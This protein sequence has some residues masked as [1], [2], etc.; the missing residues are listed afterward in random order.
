MD[1]QSPV[2][3]FVATPRK[4]LFA[5][6]L[7]GLLLGILLVLFGG[8]GLHAV[9]SSSSSHQSITT[10]DTPLYWVAPMDANYRRDEPGKS[11]MGMDL[12]PVYERGENSSAGAVTIAPEVI[13]S[14]GVKTFTVTR[15]IPDS[16]FSAFGELAYPEHTQVSIHSR[17]T[18]W[19][20]ELL[21]RTNGAYVHQGQPLYSLYAPELVFAQEEYLVALEQQS[22]PLID[23][24]KRRLQ[25]LAAPEP[26]IKSLTE[27]RTVEQNVV[28]YA[29]QDGFVINLAVKEGMYIKPDLTFMTLVDTSQMWLI[30][31][32]Y[33]QD[34]N[35]V[36]IGQEVQL[37]SEI[38]L[39]QTVTGTIDYIY[40]A[41]S[42]V[43]RTTQVRVV[44]P[45]PK[46]VLR[47]GQ[48]V[49]AEIIPVN[50]VEPRLLVP[51]DAII[52][53]GQ[54]DRVVLALGDGQFKSIE[55]SLGQRYRNGFA[56]TAGLQ[57]GDEIVTAAHFLL[58]SESS[59][60]SDFMRM[61]GTATDS[62]LEHG[63]DSEELSDWTHA[64]VNEVMLTERMLN[65]THGPLENIGMMGMTMN[66]LVA[67]DID[68]S[69]LSS[70]MEVHVEIVPTTSGM[71]EVR[72]LHVT[73]DMEMAQ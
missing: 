70:A 50:D 32:L 63:S 34:I 61:E 52:R 51:A 72:T 15:S 18:G 48:F 3:Q 66:F 27:T 55:V 67:E 73:Q 7:V 62:T 4:T 23:A 21:V 14:L 49:Q 57:E 1:S 29:P 2:S 53:T 59:I 19:I 28:F 60:S 65:L 5:A 69:V 11:P 16:R 9:A 41:V 36:S 42:E 22:G 8:M 13:Q 24:A 17:T 30:L 33:A 35:K 45:N 25:A 39:N 47:A 10:D 43:R 71:Y 38:L 6:T 31:D 20:V 40:P 56:I 46:L 26:L 37:R 58:D 12:V 64:T 68:L 44:L 54:Q